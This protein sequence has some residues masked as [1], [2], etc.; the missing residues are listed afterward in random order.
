MKHKKSFLIFLAVLLILMSFFTVWALADAGNFSGD[1]DWGGGGS[2]DWG[3]SDWDSDWDSGS[4]SSGGG[5]GSIGSVVIFIIIFAAVYVVVQAKS[6]SSGNKST[7]VQTAFPKDLRPLSELKAADPNFSEDAMKE[8][9]ANLY[10]RLQGAWQA[11]DLR[12]V[13]TSLSDALYNQFDGQ[14]EAFRKAKN[15]NFVDRIAVLGVT[16]DGWRREETNDCIVATLN[17]RIVDYTLDDVTGKLISGSQT[18]EKFMTYRWMLT[19]SAGMVTPK[20]DGG[21][22]EISCPSCGAP[23]E[24]NQ[25]ARCAYCGS[26]VSSSDYDWL[27]STI[28]GIAQRTGN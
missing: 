15:T 4:G 11:K 25:S 17:T 14:L 5:H 19:R 27:L 16:L 6:K 10:V 9:I 3:S 21:T 7:T 18:K 24:L 8:K 1:S 26:I 28:Q 2:S 12:P 22:V 13:R 23:I 20:V